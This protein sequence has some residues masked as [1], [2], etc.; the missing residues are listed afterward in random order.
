M[1]DAGALLA[2]RIKE[3]LKEVEYHELAAMNAAEAARL[4]RSRLQRLTERLLDE[5]E[6]ER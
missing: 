2:G 5:L 4:A 6:N 3:V 1:T